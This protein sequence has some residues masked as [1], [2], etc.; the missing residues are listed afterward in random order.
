MTNK[1]IIDSNGWAIIGESWSTYPGWNPS[2]I[3]S[4]S[5]KM[6]APL[7]IDMWVLY[8]QNGGLYYGHP[9]GNTDIIIF[10]LN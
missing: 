7:W 5:E 4:I 8:S 3:T 1:I 2:A 10:E 6:L 9:N